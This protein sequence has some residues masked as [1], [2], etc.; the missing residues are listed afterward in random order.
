MAA[1]K[2]EYK[3]DSKLTGD[4]VMINA[5]LGNNMDFIRQKEC[6]T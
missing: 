2:V 1:L 3:G 6:G 5:Q 4:K